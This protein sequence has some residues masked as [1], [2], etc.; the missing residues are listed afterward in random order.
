MIRILTTG[1][2]AENNFGSPSIMHGLET[3]LDGLYGNDYKLVHIQP[4]PVCDL[5]VSDFK[6]DIRYYKFNFK[7]LIVYAW[8]YKF[9]RYIPSNKEGEIIRLVL[10]SDIICDLYGI[11]FCD[12]F[13]RNTKENKF[14]SA[15]NAIGLFPLEYVGKILGK[16]TVKNTASFGPMK[17]KGNQQTARFACEKIFSEISAREKQSYDAIKNDAKVK[18]DVYI[19][20]DIA[21]LFNI[22]NIETNNDKIGI[23]ISHQI[24][25]QWKSKDGYVDC[26]VEL[27]KYITSKYKKSIVLIPNEYVPGKKANDI[28]VANEIQKILV[29]REKISV[30][31]ADV[32]NMT[33]TSLKQEIASCDVM[34][35]SRYHACVASYSSGVP[36]LIIGWHYKYQELAELYGQERWILSSEK[37]DINSLIDTFDSF[38]NDK[39]NIRSVIKERYNEVEKKVNEVGKQLFTIKK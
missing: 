27:C 26:I 24:V 23:S 8:A 25:R 33:S 6:M 17:S 30:K 36:L 38:Y 34:V 28:D 18:K 29:E 9:F 20:P 10:S 14:K 37:C 2:M 19:S 35:A 1:I 31:I 12:N 21:N 15:F 32:Q 39:E 13:N 3:L 16:K 11:R 7:K 4:T 5:A 22:P